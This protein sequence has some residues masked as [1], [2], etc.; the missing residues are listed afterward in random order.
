M[1]ILVTTALTIL[2]FT[3]CF[4]QSN[5]PPTDKS[6]LDV[7][8]CPA[9]YPL[10]KVQDRNT[11]PLLARVIYSR[12]QINGRTIFGDLIE[13]GKVWRLGANEATEIEFFQNVIIS[14]NKIKKGRYTLYAIP[15]L[16]NWTIILNKD[17]DTWGS[18]KYDST[19]DVM[20][21]T[22]PVQK[23]TDSTETFSMYFEKVDNGY[24]LNA[25]WENAKVSL[26]I[27]LQ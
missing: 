23:Q 1:K 8:Y 22:L 10:L 18:F 16:D 13:Y 12:P 14:N 3:F 19:K 17:L 15:Q 20:R 2:S 27:S 11:E 21:V 6:P 5:I 7:S 26:P 4:S 25:I 24:N 9:N